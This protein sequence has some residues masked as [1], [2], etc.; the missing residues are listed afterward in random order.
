MH[1]I[2]VH[3][4]VVEISEKSKVRIKQAPVGTFMAWQVIMQYTVLII[5][6]LP[7]KL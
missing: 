6:Q 2:P 3:L 1:M 4:I 7:V 5:I